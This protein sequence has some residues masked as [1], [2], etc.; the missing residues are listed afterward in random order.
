SDEE[1]DLLVQIEA[2]ADAADEAAAAD[3]QDEEREIVYRLS[4]DG[5]K[6]Q[7]EGAE[8][9]PKAEAVKVAGRWGVK[10][11]VEATTTSEKVLMAPNSGPLAF[12]GQAMRGSAP[13]K[14]SDRREGDGELK[15]VPGETVKFSRTWPGPDQK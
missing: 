6:V 14:F 9:R 13:S 7:I 10:L 2:S 4:Q 5:L 3:A 15:L 11:T 12:G 1:A 8:F